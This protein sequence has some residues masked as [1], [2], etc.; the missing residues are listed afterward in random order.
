M[1]EKIE[2][3][4]LLGRTGVVT[5]RVTSTVRGREGCSVRDMRGIGGRSMTAGNFGTEL[6]NKD[7]LERG[8]EPA[9][10]SSAMVLDGRWE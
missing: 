1:D 9:G 4:Q 2:G 8:Q 5:G 10:T 3:L 6:E 7:G